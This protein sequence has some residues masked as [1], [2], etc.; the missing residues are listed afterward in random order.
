MTLKKAVAKIGPVAIGIDAGQPGFSSY[1][2]GIYR[3]S[4]C[5]AARVNHAVVLVG[6]GTEYGRDYWLVK[7][8]YNTIISIKLNHFNTNKSI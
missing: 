7:N 1:S 5:N 8:R 3:S 6:Y 2:N 4:S